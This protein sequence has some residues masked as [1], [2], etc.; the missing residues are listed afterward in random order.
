[1]DTVHGLRQMP[2]F[3]DLAREELERIAPMTRAQKFGRYQ[4]IIRAGERGAVVFLLTAGAVRVS[5]AGPGGKEVMVGV[6]YPGDI[7][8]E[9]AILD[10]RPRSATVT[11]MEETEVLAIRR[12]DFLDFIREV[13]DAAAKMIITLCL[14]LRRMNQKAGDLAY[15]RAPQRVARMLLELAQG[16]GQPTSAGTVVEVPFTHRELAELAGVSR[17]TFTRLLAMFQRRGLLTLKRRQLCIQAHS[18]LEK[19]V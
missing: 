16:Q 19:F 1:M 6:L 12:Q 14:R 15:G 4:V 8:G 13:P 17:E 18:Q 11:A 9:M 7:F 5:V 3:A 10:G 2:L